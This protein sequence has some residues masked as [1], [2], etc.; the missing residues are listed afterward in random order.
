M[1][2]PST[3][4]LPADYFVS[5]HQFTKTVHR[6]QYPSID[7]T[8]PKLSQ[9]GKTVIISGASQGLGKVF[10]ASIVTCLFVYDY[11]L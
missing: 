10:H 9:K 5:L 7:P 1:A 3:P 6:D 8:S 2:E 4:S 11:Q